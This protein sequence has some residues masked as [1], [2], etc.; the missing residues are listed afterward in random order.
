MTTTCTGRATFWDLSVAAMR[1][2]HAHSF[3]ARPHSSVAT[4]PKQEGGPYEGGY[5]VVDIQIPTKYPYEPPKMRFD[6]KVWHPN[7]SSQ[8]GAICLDILKD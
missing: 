1:G 3:L 6:T 8:N 7:V 5:F 2:A 4:D